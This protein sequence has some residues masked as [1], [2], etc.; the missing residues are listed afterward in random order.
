MKIRHR[1]PPNQDQSSSRYQSRSQSRSGPFLL[2]LEE[3]EQRYVGDFDDFEADAGNV[4]D[5]VAGSTESRHQNLVV[6]LDVVQ[7][8]VL[9]DKG[10]DLLSVFDE[11]N[12]DALPDGRVGLLSL[13][14]DLLQNDPFHVR[15]TAERIRFQGGSRVSLLVILVSPSLDASMSPDFAGGFQSTRFSHFYF[16]IFFNFLLIFFLYKNFKQIETTQL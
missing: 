16:L 10:G 9:G 11:L 1:R 15:S 6:L 2:L 3:G 8:T 14:A 13:H 5:G 4:A 7:A 12:S